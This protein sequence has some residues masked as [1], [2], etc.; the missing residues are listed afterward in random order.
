M[1]ASMPGF[2]TTTVS[3]LSIGDT[4]FLQDF[5]L[6]FRSVQAPGN[7]PVASCSPSGIVWCSVLHRAK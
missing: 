4:E 7:P 5:T 2:K 1:T 6:E 3:N